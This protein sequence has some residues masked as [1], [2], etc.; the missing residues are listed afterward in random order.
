MFEWLNDLKIS[1]K[2]LLMLSIPLLGLLFFSALEI[3]DKWLELD[4]AQAVQETVLLSQ[5]LDAVA[6]NFAVARGLS[7]GFLSSGGKRFAPELRSLCLLFGLEFTG[8]GTGTEIGGA[9][10]SAG[11]YTPGA[12]LC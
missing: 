2:L 8:P 11:N 1:H 9:H 3:S 6:H 5:H 7:A 12:C 4:E 10:Q